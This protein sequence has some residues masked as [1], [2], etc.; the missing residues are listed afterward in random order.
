MSELR[1]IIKLTD[2]AGACGT[3]ELNFLRWVVAEGTADDTLLSAFT[4]QRR[5]DADTVGLH[6]IAGVLQQVWQGGVALPASMLKQPAEPEVLIIALLASAEGGGMV[7]DLEHLY[8]TVFAGNHQVGDDEYGDP[9]SAE[10]FTAMAAEQL[11]KVEA[12]P[13]NELQP[14]AL[15]GHVRHAGAVLEVRIAP[16]FLP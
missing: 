4:Q 2:I 7:R 1:T 15:F 10:A 14:I 6:F 9:Y 5:C 13:D 16:S 8:K 3:V 11:E 12:V